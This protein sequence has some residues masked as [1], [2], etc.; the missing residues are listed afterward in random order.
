MMK[1]ITINKYDIHKGSLMLVNACNPLVTSIREDQL[2]ILAASRQ[3]PRVLMERGAATI[4]SHVMD[5]IHCGDDIIPVSGYR[6]VHEQ[7]LIYND[8]LTENGEEFT[9]KYVALPNR[10]EHQTGLAIDLGLNRGDIDFIRPHFPNEGICKEFRKKAVKFGFIERYPSGK[11]AITGI[12]HEPWHFRYVG[13]PHSLIMNERGLTLEEYIEYVKSFP[14]DR[15][16]LITERNGQLIEIYY[17]PFLISDAL[18]FPLS[19]YELYQ[20][21]GNNVDGFIVTIWR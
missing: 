5:S 19:E 15:K 18:A 14:F 16:H 9:K 21:S 13:Y 3:F 7:E 12:A 11:E 8:S 17:I 10:S 2:S 20:I 1:T 4:L 6:S